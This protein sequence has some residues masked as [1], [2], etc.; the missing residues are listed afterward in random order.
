MLESES[1]LSVP[2][3]TLP[4]NTNNDENHRNSPFGYDGE[5]RD[6]LSTEVTTTTSPALLS[7]SSSTSLLSVY[8]TENTQLATKNIRRT[9]AL[10]FFTFTSRSVWSQSL[11]SIYVILVWKDHPEYVGYVLAT[12]GISLY[13]ITFQQSTFYIFLL[14]NGLWGMSWGVLESILPNV[15]AESAS[16]VAVNNKLA[17][18]T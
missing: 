3:L 14:A 2:F 16:L 5:F 7:S 1:T 11:L 6:A 13:A 4:I 10:T 17:E 15:F 12:M 18:R 8:P 9:L